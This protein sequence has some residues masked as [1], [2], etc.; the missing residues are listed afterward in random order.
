MM[1]RLPGEHADRDATGACPFAERAV[2]HNTPLALFSHFPKQ[3]A[4]EEREY[5]SAV[6]GLELRGSSR[7]ADRA[8]VRGGSNAF[9]VAAVSYLVAPDLHRCQCIPVVW[10][11]CGQAH[12]SK[13]HYHGPSSRQIAM[14]RQGSKAGGSS[15]KRGPSRPACF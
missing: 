11:R 2:C 9:S 15:C 8:T 12:Q 5:Y 1:T 7:R 6:A 10:I 4:C 14:A 13:Q 3:P